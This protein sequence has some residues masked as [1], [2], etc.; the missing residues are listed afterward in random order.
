MSGVRQHFI[1]QFLQKGFRIPSN[2]KTVRCWVYEHTRAP[3]P[4]NIAD[5]GL[6]RRFYA[7]Q[8]ETDLDDKITEAEREVY[9][10]L[11][12]RLRKGYARPEDTSLIAE[13][14]AHFEVRSR[15]VR[16]NMG[17]LFEEVTSQIMSYL[18]D[19]HI[20][21]LLI[22]EHLTPESE[23][24]RKAL[25]QH[26]I[27]LD[28]MQS[29]LQ[30]SQT[31]LKEA[32]R[33]MTERFA[34]DITNA[35][36]SFLPQIN[37]IVKQ[38]HVRIMSESI[39]PSARAARLAVMH[40]SVKSFEPDNLPLGDSIVL[41]HVKGDRAF[42]PFLDK[43]DEVIHVVLPLSSNQYLLG[44]AAGAVGDLNYD[45]VEQVARCSMRYF[46]SCSDQMSD[47]QEKIGS[48][49]RWISQAETQSLMANVIK[50]MLPK[51]I[52]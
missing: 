19:P 30:H 46:I 49:S 28:Q 8:A 26:G 15:H 42:K 38:S 10:P 44:S 6:V 51:S 52:I 4:A 11:I 37:A 48:N 16:E 27:T 41:F 29:I 12:D 3:R 9:A 40:Y 25:A 21:G 39:S 45:L 1:P 32:L 18:A 36:P 43:H 35:L 23:I 47:L 22:D 7:I 2:G 31:T 50:E 24:F 5:V 34:A 14:L 13:M 33:P 20:L 17:E